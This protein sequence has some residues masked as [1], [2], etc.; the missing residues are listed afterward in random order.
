[1]KATAFRNLGNALSKL[2][3]HKDAVEAY[4]HAL[5]L[6]PDDKAAKWNLEIALRKQ[7]EEEKKKQD[8]KDKDKDKDDKKDDKDKRQRQEGRQG[9]ED[10]D[11]KK[12]KKDKDKDKKDQQ[13]KQRPEGQGQAGEAAAARESGAE[14]ARAH[15]GDA[16]EPRGESEGSRKGAGP[17]ARGA[18]RAAGAGLVMPASAKRPLASL[19]LALATVAALAPTA[20]QAGA[21]ASSFSASI[22]RAAVAPDQPF[23]YRVTLTTSDGQPEGF[24]P[25]DFRGLRVVGG[26]FTQT[27]MSMQ[28][29]SGGTRVENSVTWSYQL[30]VPQGTK[31]QVAIGAAH[32]RVGGQDLSSNAVQV[33]IGAPAA[34]PPPA[35]RPQ[36][37]PDLFPRGMFGDD[38]P[39]EQSRSR[40]R[41][42]G[43]SSAPSPTRRRPSWA[44]R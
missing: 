41:R 1:M 22:D 16:E 5:A 28:V 36:R 17:P 32:V 25:P 29:G 15:P 2:E 26:P 14:S 12:D 20:A 4:K 27:G 11:D 43:R 44:S 23:L 7:K 6:R 9:Q 35:Q 42:P 34:A 24:K 38:E 19:A 33:R 37:G 18:P 8:D 39:E 21:G 10:K 31:G 40:R 13:D 3:K 30:T